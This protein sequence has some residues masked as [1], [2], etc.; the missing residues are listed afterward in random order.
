LVRE[1]AE[2]LLAKEKELAAETKKRLEEHLASFV[3]KLLNEITKRARNIRK[4]RISE[5]QNTK[6]TY[7]KFTR[8]L[9]KCEN[10]E[11]DSST[12]KGGNQDQIEWLEPF[13]RACL[14][15]RIGERRMIEIVPAY[16][17][18]TALTSYNSITAIG[19]NENCNNLSKCWRDKI[20]PKDFLQ[21][22]NN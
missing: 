2:G 1:R 4:K 10:D 7:N 21:S 22:K 3:L 9:D 11:A 8:Y 16:L 5:V 17:K 12:F 15:I 20:K 6:E 19:W 14:A 13:E 18:G